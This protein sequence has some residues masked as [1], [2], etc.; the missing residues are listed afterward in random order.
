MENIIGYYLEGV[1]QPADKRVYKKYFNHTVAVAYLENELLES[2]NREMDTILKNSPGAFYSA[3]RFL[4]A[5][6]TYLSHL[7]WGYI[8]KKKNEGKDVAKFMRKFKILSPT[9]G[10]HYE[11]FRHGLLHTHHPK[12]IK[13]GG[14]IAEW[15]IG[16]D[17]KLKRFGIYLPEFY[18]E[19]KNSINLFVEEL[20]EEQIQGKKTR[21]NKM[22]EGFSEAV[23][24]LSVQDLST[25]SKNDFTKLKL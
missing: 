11:V 3:V 21:L 19:I 14:K 20:E 7:Y 24:I 2:L 25:Y 9:Y 10:L 6:L 12:W 4:F 23:K 5:E 16:S 17:V 22:F 1:W 13:K 15:Y 18:A 8:P